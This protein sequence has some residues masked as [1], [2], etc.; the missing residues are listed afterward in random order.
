MPALKIDPTGVFT[1]TGLAVPVDGGRMLLHTADRDPQLPDLR[2]ATSP[3][4]MSRRLKLGYRA[5]C[6]CL[7]YRP[8]KRCTLAYVDKHQSE[9]FVVGK[10]FS[11]GLFDSAPALHR[12]VRAALQKATSD[13]FEI[14]RVLRSLADLRMIVFTGVPEVNGM[15]RTDLAVAAGRVLAGLHEIRNA[16]HTPFRIEDE[17][18]AV[19]RW[20]ILIDRLRRLDSRTRRLHFW[21][22]RVGRR[23]QQGPRVLL[24]RDFY[25]AQLVAT[26]GGWALV[27]L[28]TVGVG[29]R[30]LDIANYVAHLIWNGIRTYGPRKARREAATFLHSYLKRQRGKFPGLN[31]RRLRFYLV[32]SLVRVSLIHS[33]RSGEQVAAKSLLRVAERW[34]RCP[35]QRCLPRLVN[36]RK[37]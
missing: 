6:R 37:D 24:H 8:G 1:L 18:K 23:L 33:L 30:E 28:D 20:I 4:A 27:D 34:A 19:E 22:K 36:S 3:L 31:G 13:P 15:C 29:D 25:D 11:N 9:R 35:A 32:S 26:R 14:P 16:T 10:V 5:R 7:S 21:M 17:T 12:R 2:A